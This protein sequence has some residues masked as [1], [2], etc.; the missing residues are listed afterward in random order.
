MLSDEQ[1]GGR[2]KSRGSKDQLL[3]DKMMTRNCKRRLTGLGM[4]WVDYK[5]AYDMGTSFLDKKV[6]ANV[7]G[8]RKCN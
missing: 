3:I 2:R 5:K 4:A 6:H 1:K 7:W 8:S